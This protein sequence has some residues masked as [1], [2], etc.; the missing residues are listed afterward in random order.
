MFGLIKLRRQSLRSK[1]ADV[2][3]FPRTPRQRLRYAREEAQRFLSR[4]TRDFACIQRSRTLWTDRRRYRGPEPGDSTHKGSGFLLTTKRRTM[5][6]G[7]TEDY[8]A[9]D[10][11]QA[12]LTGL[13]RAAGLRERTSH[14][15]RRPFATRLVE[16]AMTSRSC[17]G[18]SATPN[19]TCACANSSPRRSPAIFVPFAISLFSSRPRPTPRAPRTCVAFRC[20]VS[21]RQICMN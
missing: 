15:G 1:A 7:G 14:S 9:R 4:N 16:E 5:A 17:S 8:L 13:Y 6:A 10:S 2:L 21:Y 11:L 12:H 20:T 3:I 19:W 18:P